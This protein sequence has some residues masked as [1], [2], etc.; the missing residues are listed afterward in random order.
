MTSLKPKNITLKTK[1]GSYPIIVGMN[2]ERELVRA[3]EREGAHRIA[4]IADKT[5]AKLFAPSV[6]R[7]LKKAGHPA[8]VFHFKGGERDKTMKT[9]NALQYALLEKGFGRD[10]L[11]VA[12]GGGVVGDVAGFAAATFMR[13][14]PYI[15]MP[16]TL[17]A[18]VDSSIGGKVG[19][20]TE[21]GKN[22]IGAFHQPRA[23]IADVSFLARLSEEQV[24][25]GLVEAVKKFMTSNKKMLAAVMRLNLERPLKDRA[26]LLKIVH[27]AVSIKARVVAKDEEEK[28]ERRILNFGHTVGHAI[29][30]CSGYRM[31][32][33]FAVAYGILVETKVA[34]LLG[35]LSKK[36]CAVV[37]AY[38]A[39]LGFTPRVFE[40]FPVQAIVRAMKGDKKTKRGKLY[41]VLLSRVGAVYRKGGAYAHPVSEH[42]VEKAYLSLIRP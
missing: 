12:L 11:I 42:V 20:D 34:E 16:T 3:V 27:A 2:I 41:M 35:V 33:G 19:V 39:H 5:T 24:L 18:M 13:G 26:L 21:H 25:N 4:I 23:V 30:Q 15:Q 28:N 10:T 32:H 31:P 37:H 17:L 29:E 1:D 22:M 9:V 36:E 6:A 7:A 38:L 8:E 14:V 40:K